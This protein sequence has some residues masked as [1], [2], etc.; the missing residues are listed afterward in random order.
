M[1][2]QNLRKKV[3][4][5]KKKTTKKLLLPLCLMALCIMTMKIP[6][7]PSDTQEEPPQ[8]R[9]LSYRDYDDNTEDH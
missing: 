7:V 4:T 6:V 9:P 8:I 5:M 1:S 2:F 3:S